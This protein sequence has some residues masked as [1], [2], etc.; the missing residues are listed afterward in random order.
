MRTTKWANK[1]VKDYTI[2]MSSH[3][4]NAQYTEQRI[5]HF[6]N[7]PL[8]SC[9]PGA[10]SIE[11]IVASLQ[12]SPDFSADQREWETHERIM[13]V[14][15]LQN[16]MVPLEQHIQLA[17]TIDSLLRNGYVGRAPATPG[18]S[19][20]FKRIHEKQ[21]RGESF[22]QSKTLHTAQRSTALIGISGMGKTTTVKRIC[23]SFPKVI[24]H[25]DYNL[26]QIPT[27]HVEMPSDGSS[28][29]GLANGI[30][31]KIDELI[32]DANYYAHYGRGGRTGADSLM[33]SVARLMHLHAVG[34]LIC[35]ELQNLSNSRKSGQTV[36]TEL[37]S[38]C[39]DLNVPILFIGT[40]K[41][42]KILGMDFR[43]AR[44]ATGSGTSY[45]DRLIPCPNGG[46]SSW[47]DFINVLWRFQWIRKPVPLDDQFKNIMFDYS[48]GVIDLAI[49]LF[50]TAQIEAMRTG[51]ETITYHALDQIYR[52]DFK[53]LHPMLEALRRGDW[54]A[55]VQYEDI[56][57]VSLD[58]SIPLP[59]VGLN[60][61]SPSVTTNATVE[62]KF[63]QHNIKRDSASTVALNRDATLTRS[64]T[65]P[66]SSTTS[67][68]RNTESKKNISPASVDQFDDRPD[69]YRRAITHARANNVLIF[70]KLK[71]FNMAPTL[72]DVLMI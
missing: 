43:Q 17:T 52:R 35:D 2:I 64:K 23:S 48:Q 65:V 37:V 13:M 1:P 33:R 46:S 20:I 53:L 66:S 14:G 3:I 34:I 59:I 4:V 40:N 58:D 26:Y 44:R 70:E 62:R 38:A 16:F 19:Q 9:L 36:M 6:R 56:A 7:N 63:N 60:N 54:A 32:P 42:S 51:H 31:Q 29:K 5:P 49:K 57:P 28:I 22:T 8:I 27:L 15:Q 50:S 11:Q 12:D 61:Y 25:S 39:N 69:D 47:D 45:W 21:S 41:A 71:E 30:L 72:E 18:H 55:L 67:V 24:Y 68:I 10:K